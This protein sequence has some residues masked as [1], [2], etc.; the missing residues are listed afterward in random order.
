MTVNQITAGI[1]SVTTA[2]TFK[3][4]VYSLDGA[5]KYIDVTTGTV[6]TPTVSATVAG[7]V[8]NPGEYYAVVGCATTCSDAMYG[9]TADSSA[10]FG[11]STPAGKTIWRGTVSHTSGTCNS[12]LGT[13][14]GTNTVIPVFRFDN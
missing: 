10:M 2:G 11:T 5:T 8:L 12:T 9:T 13:I 3:L 14:T 1:S 7:V 6:G 4:C